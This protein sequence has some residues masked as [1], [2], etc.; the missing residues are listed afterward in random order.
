MHNAETRAPVLIVFFNRPQTLEKVFAA[1]KSAKPSVLLLAQDGARADRPDD[2]E[3]IAACRRIVEDIDWDC[4]VYKNYSDVNLSCDHREFTALD[5]AFSIVDRLIVLEDD[6][7]PCPSFFPFC[8]ELLEKYKDDTRVDRISGF[9]RLE[10][11]E[12]ISADYFFSTIAAGYGWATWKR[13]WEQIAAQKDYAFL[14]D[15]DL[16]S[17]FNA[18]RKTIADRN[19][20]D[21]LQ[22][23]RALREKDRKTGKFNSWETL[24]GVN[25]LINGSLII[26]PRCNMVVNIGATE[27]ATH[28][29]EMKYTDAITRR[30]LQMKAC[31][32]SFPLKHPQHVFRDANYEKKHYRA[33]HRSPLRKIALK[34]DVL[35]RRLF[36]GDFSGVFRAVRRRLKKKA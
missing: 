4:T 7:V 21:I 1:V 28:Y 34:L 2:A 29:A 18:S 3:K 14:D 23:C 12:D 36:G 16:V 6:C 5:W 33:I 24:V 27:N 31:D 9:N 30:L 15:I 35:T 11:Y 17:V 19:Y 22:Q 8:D 26:T 25:S 32:V 13:T 10:K 20:G